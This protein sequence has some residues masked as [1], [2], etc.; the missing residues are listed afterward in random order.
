[1]SDKKIEEQPEETVTVHNLRSR[2]VY[3]STSGIEEV[4]NQRKKINTSHRQE[5]I[6]ADA[7]Q[8]EVAELEQQ[9]QKLEIQ[10]LDV[11]DK[12]TK[13]ESQQKLLDEKISDDAVK[14]A[15]T[16]PNLP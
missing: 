13:D 3:K 10:N 1:M 12:T 2:Q 11:F 7:N 14:K 6:S 8:A 15:P 9:L 16:A 4:K 5:H